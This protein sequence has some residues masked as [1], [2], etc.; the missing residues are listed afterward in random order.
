MIIALDMDEVLCDLLTPWLKWIN[1]QTGE[2]LTH[3]KIIS[4]RMADHTKLGINADLFIQTPAPFL[5][6]KP[7][8]G[9]IKGVRYLISKGYKI[10]I[11]SAAHSNVTTAKTNWLKDHLPEIQKEDI[12]FRYN[13]F[14]VDADVLI[15][16]HIRNLEAWPTRSICFDRPYN[17]AWQGERVKSWEEIKELF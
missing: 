14:T 8:K 1:K 7:I 5:K 9:A 2:D 16:D 10:K 13:K 12:F 6:L 11:V 17:K 3:D 4:F 15:D